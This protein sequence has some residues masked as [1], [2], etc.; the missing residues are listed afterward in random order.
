[1]EFDSAGVKRLIAKVVNAFRKDGMEEIS[2]TVDTIQNEMQKPGDPVTHPIEWDSEKQRRAFFATDG[3]GKGIPYVR[4]GAYAQG[5]QKAELPEG[6]S[7]TNKE[8]GAA[9]VGGWL[10]GN[11]I[12]TATARQ[13]RIHFKR[14]KNILIPIRE[15]LSSLTK[16]VVDRLR[17]TLGRND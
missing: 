8:R 13:S 5:Y 10:K 3:F 6:Y 7:L 4:R 14:W 1:M 16:R 17:V 12:L 2:A 11:S 9:A 15:T